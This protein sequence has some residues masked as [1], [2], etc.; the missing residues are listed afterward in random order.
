MSRYSKTIGNRTMNYGFDHALG[1][2]FDI[3]DNTVKDVPLVV[4]DESSF[5]TKLSRARFLEVM[6]D[7]DVLNNHKV[8]VAMD[9]EF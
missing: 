5:F 4:A 2:W 9:L 7:F 3:E 1:Y 8:A 6:E